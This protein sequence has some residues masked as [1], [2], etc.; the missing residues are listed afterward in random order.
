MG[1]WS[2]PDTDEKKQKVLDAIDKLD[3]LEHE[4]YH[5]YGDDELFDHLDLAIGM[6][7]L[8]V[9]TTTPQRQRFCDGE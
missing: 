6:L 7:E 4:L 2:L 5:V 8:A 3:A 9:G 1:T